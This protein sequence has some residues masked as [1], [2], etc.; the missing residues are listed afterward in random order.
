ML[1]NGYDTTERRGVSADGG[2]PRIGQQALLTA[3]G[4]PVLCA[5]LEALDYCEP[6]MLS[7][8]AELTFLPSTA[9]G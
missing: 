9:L 2:E 7:M 5:T 3:R 8:V 4:K 1:E 6:V